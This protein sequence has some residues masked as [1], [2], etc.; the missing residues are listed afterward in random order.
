MERWLRDDC[1][2]KIGNVWF[3]AKTLESRMLASLGK[4]YLLETQNVF[5]CIQ[6]IQTKKST[7]S[8]SRSL[9]EGGCTRR[10]P[11]NWCSGKSTWPM[12]PCHGYWDLNWCGPTDPSEIGPAWLPSK[13]RTCHQLPRAQYLL[14]AASWQRMRTCHICSLLV[15]NHLKICRTLKHLKTIRK[16]QETQ[17]QLKT[18]IDSIDVIDVMMFVSLQYMFSSLQ[19]FRIWWIFISAWHRLRDCCRP[20]AL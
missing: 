15:G 2:W 13:V 19:D 1:T 11:G 4:I 9:A 6:C 7:M 16:H 3:G 10:T 17:F 8:I 5:K 18:L 20:T 12:V 14:T